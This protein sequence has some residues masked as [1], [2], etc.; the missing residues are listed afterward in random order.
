MILRSRGSTGPSIAASLPLAPGL[1]SLRSISSS[2]SSSRG[3]RSVVEGNE[4]ETQREIRSKTRQGEGGTQ[5][6]H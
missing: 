6:L 4:L 2:S 3:R 1:V 5:V